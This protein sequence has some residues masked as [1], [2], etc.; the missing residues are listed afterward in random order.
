MK[1][2]EAIWSN[3][4]IV[5]TSYI[6]DVDSLIFLCI[7]QQLVG[8]GADLGVHDE[9]GYY[10]LALLLVEMDLQG[11]DVV[12][13]QPQLLHFTPESTLPV[14]AVDVVHHFKLDQVLGE[15]DVTAVEHFVTQFVLVKLE[16]V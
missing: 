15:T 12:L 4:L 5:I 3:L 16:H 2:S 1:V 9:V 7:P 14:F 6:S 10:Y 8:F 13:D 11:F